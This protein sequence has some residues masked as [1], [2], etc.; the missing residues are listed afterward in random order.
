MKNMT[1]ACRKKEGKKERKQHNRNNNTNPI[2]GRNVK[3]A[4]LLSENIFS[5]QS[6]IIKAMGGGGVVASVP[7]A[8]GYFIKEE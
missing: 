7:Y 4:Y 8:T 6:S 5:E 3:S 1:V 2:K